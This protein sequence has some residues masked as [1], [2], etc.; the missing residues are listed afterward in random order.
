MRKLG[1]VLLVFALV[2]ASAVGL[3]AC[4]SSS[5]GKE[6]GTLTGSYASFPEYLDPQLSY[7]SKAG[8]RSGTPTAAAHL[9]PRQ[10]QGGQQ[11]HPGSRHG[12][13][14][15]HQRRQDLHALPA[16]G[17][18]YSDGTPVKASDFPATVERLFKLNSGGIALLHQHRRRRKVRRNQE[19]GITGIKTNDK[20]GEIVIDL[21]KPRGTF[22]DE[23]A[24]L[25]VAPGAERH[26]GQEPDRESAAGHRALRDHQVRTGAR[27]DL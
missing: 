21:E 12:A 16:K 27:L 23:L 7:T 20:T 15:D 13:A 24:M 5:S 4:G 2:A 19:G 9:R 8:R 25:F 10:R 17:L 22:T 1:S 26:A 11:G 6:G 14:Q 3:R 18:K